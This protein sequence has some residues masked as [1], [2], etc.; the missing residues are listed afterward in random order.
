MTDEAVLVELARIKDQIELFGSTA[1]ANK[2]AGSIW[3]TGWKEL[4]NSVMLT[5]QICWWP[6]SKVFLD[7][8]QRGFPV[9]FYHICLPSME[10]VVNQGER[11]KFPLEWDLKDSV[12]ADTPES[13]LRRLVLEGMRKLIEYVLADSPSWIDDVVCFSKEKWLKR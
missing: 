6:S 11:T 13:E 5:G 1:S 10:I 8:K 7:A 3:F 2:P 12:S 9:K 4:P